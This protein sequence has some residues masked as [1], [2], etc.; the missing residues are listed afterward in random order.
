MRL[1]LVGCGEIGR[2]VA[3]GS[4]LNPRLSLTAVVD[5]SPEKAERLARGRVV[6]T[7]SLSDAISVG[8]ADAVYLG[9]PHDLHEPLFRQ[10]AA[11]GLAVLCEK[12]LAHT[13][14]SGDLMLK[15]AAAHRVKLGVN[16]QYRYDPRLHRLARAVQAGALGELRL[17]RAVVP[18]ERD[19]G[20][21]QQAP[22]HASR[23][24]AGGGTLITQASHALDAALWVSGAS[25]ERAFA[26]TRQTRRAAGN[27]EDVAVGM[28]ELAGGAVVEI[29]GTMSIHPE[30]P[31]SLEVYGSAGSAHYRP[32]RPL[33]AKGCRIPRY[34]APAPGIHPLFRSL[35]GFRR[36]VEA[37]SGK[38]RPRDTEYLTPAEEAWE[39][40]RVV[41]AL[42]R[43]AAAGLPQPVVPESVEAT[44][45]G[46]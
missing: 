34:P 42:Y 1:I 12:P 31:L 14:A 18:W 8:Q 5:P 7:S 37:T 25:A 24:R 6:A 41:D 21:F 17:I 38:P 10:A 44:G 4:R 23:E 9:V 16:Y 3:L 28:L 20:Y 45:G 26:V 29:A 39:T 13:R 27:V 33:Q 15:V 22:W 40:L 19:D 43:S 35:E 46:E 30:Q 36:W 32:G 11:A 2:F